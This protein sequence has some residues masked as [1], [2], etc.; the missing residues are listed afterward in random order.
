LHTS[1]LIHDDVMDNSDV[2][3]GRPA[4][5]RRFADLHTARGWHGAAND[6][7]T[8]A[9]IL[10][11]DL[12]LG[13]SDEALSRCRLPAD[14][15]AR[16][17]AV[18]GRTTTEVIAGQYLDLAA[19][20]GR[21]RSVAAALHVV[22]L[23]SARYTVQ[24]PLELGATLAG[25]GEDLVAALGAFGLPVGV[26]FQLRDDLLGVFGDPVTT[27]KPV[28]DDVREGKR[29]VLLALGYEM[30]G[31][32]GVALLD[33]L[34]GDPTLDASGVAAVQELLLTCGAQRRVESMID[35]RAQ[36]AVDVLRTAPIADPAV[37]AALVELT[38]AVTVRQV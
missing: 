37:T 1:A 16:G 7:G 18:Y 30:A 27:G 3:R 2:R 26:A 31:P 13:W 10:L 21:T 38:S 34:V 28:G 36:T 24:R 22:E 17:I 11:G 14:D 12:C 4:A 32:A 29:T 23:K 25:G 8:G 5:H 33:R 19:Q 9:A 15:L 20:A 35:E 6:F